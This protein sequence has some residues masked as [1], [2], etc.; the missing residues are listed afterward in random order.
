MLLARTKVD[1]VERWGFVEG[2][3]I[4]L[5]TRAAPPLAD[6]L[7]FDHAALREILDGSTERIATSD[8]R[9]LAP[10]PRPPQFLGVGLN[11]RDHASE[12]KMQLPAGPQVF[13]FL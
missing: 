3:Q 4:R 6:V 12:S 5:A 2:Q 10:V 1:D 13:G 7:A 11:Y 8:A 9:L